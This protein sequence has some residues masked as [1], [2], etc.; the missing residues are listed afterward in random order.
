MALSLS[1]S[2]KKNQAPP[3]SPAAA[4]AIPDDGPNSLYPPMPACPLACDAAR[5][6]PGLTVP[7]DTKHATGSDDLPLSDALLSAPSPSAGPG[8]RAAAPEQVKVQLAV[9]GGVVVSWVT[10][11]AA[12]GRASDLRRQLEASKPPP[13]SVVQFG[14]SPETLDRDATA[15]SDP[16]VVPGSP[17]GGADGAVDGLLPPG[18]G[19]SKTK[20]GSGSGGGGSG[21]PSSPLPPQPR[22]YLQS[23]SSHQAG[24]GT[25]S[26]LSGWNHHVLLRSPSQ[27]TPG[28]RVYYRVGSGPEADEEGGGGWSEVRSFV[29]PPRSTAA[30]AAEARARARGGAKDQKGEA[31]AAAATPSSSP[32]PLMLSFIGDLGTTENSTSTLRHVAATGKGGGEAGAEPDG[33]PPSAALFVVGDLVY[34]DNYAPDGGPRDFTRRGE[35]ATFQPRWDAWGRMVSA[36]GFAELP[37]AAIVGNHDVEADGEGNRAYKSFLSRFEQA[38]AGIDASSSSTASSSPASSSPASSSSSSSSSSS[39]SAAP[40]VSLEDPTLWVKDIGPA[41]VVGLNTYAPYHPGSTQKRWLERALRIPPEV[42]NSTT[43]W[44]VVL[45]H[46]PWYTS[47]ATHYREVECMRASLEP[48]FARAGVDVVVSGHVHAY[49]RTSR[50]LDHSPSPCGPVHI[51]IG[52][53]GNAER[54]YTTFADGWGVPEA[55]RARACPSKRSGDECAAKAPGPY[56]YSEQPPWSAF[57][58]PSFGHGTLAFESAEKATWRWHRNQDGER[59]VSDEFAILRG[60]ATC[61]GFVDGGE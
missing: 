37:V 14:S 7:F 45:M 13:P 57:R 42:R 58:E 4:A 43:P 60:A 48:M 59:V 5:P 22:R 15:P 61:A 34:A 47:Y 16:L 50:V 39:P 24:R 35:N 49:E 9:D 12:V 30:V 18:G 17:D 31:A 33:E 36:L 11:E 20:G 19:N 27:I 29:A 54:L 52:D 1:L 38:A 51:T 21:R 53:G 56:C 2:F 3:P 55:K 25:H 6:P 40:P 41:R 28:E 32:F 44:L 23:Y 26:Y 10:G 46:A 8:P